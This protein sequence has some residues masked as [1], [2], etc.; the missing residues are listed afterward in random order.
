MIMPDVNYRAHTHVTFIIPV[1]PG[2]LPIH[3]LA[4]TSAQI[5]ATNQQYDVN[6]VAAPKQ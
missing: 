1:H 6:I 2:A 3:L 4:A 5:T